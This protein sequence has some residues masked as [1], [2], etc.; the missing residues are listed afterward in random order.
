[1]QRDRRNIGAKGRQQFL[2][3]PCGP[4][5]PLAL[6]A[7]R[8]ADAGTIPCVHEN[9]RKNQQARAAPAT[10][11]CAYGRRR[12]KRFAAAQQAAGNRNTMQAR[13]S[14]H[15]CAPSAAARR[16]FTPRASLTCPACRLHC[17]LRRPLVLDMSGSSS[18]SFLRTLCSL[19]W[20]AIAGQAAT[21]LVASGPLGLNLPLGPLWSGVAALVAFN[22]YAIVRVRRSRGQT[23][24]A[25]A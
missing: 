13:R 2:R 16:A 18:N 22:L 15:G 20:L 8:N 14:L 6:G 24:P 10:A 3:H 1:H 17:R 25:V 9:S 19:R 4:Q 11:V 7:V 21:V 23:G 5:Q 12:S